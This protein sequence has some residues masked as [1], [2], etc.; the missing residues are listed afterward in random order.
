MDN[1]SPEPRHPIAVVA[2]RTGLSQ[3]VLRV[4]ERR[5][6]AVVP[7]RG[8]GGQRLYSDAD[9]ERLRLMHSTSRAGRNIGQVAGMSTEALAV[10]AAEDAAARPLVPERTDGSQAT[11][12]LLTVLA[13][14]K[15]LDAGSLSDELR[16]AATS[17]G[18]RTFIE[19]IAGPLMRRV[20]DEWHAGS[21]TVAQEHLATAA[22]HDLLLDMMRSFV[23]R[24]GAPR[25]L[26]ATPA[27]ERHVIGAAMVGA[28]AAADGWNVV[29]L[30]A[31]LP[32][33]DIAD[34]A[35]AS[36]ASVVAL[37]IVYAEERGRLLDEIGRIREELPHEVR[38]MVGGAG[39]RAMATSLRAIGVEV[40]SQIDRAY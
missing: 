35:R 11:E 10:L 7:L 24:P 33:A 36:R 29:Y 5:Y 14:A 39:A 22:L 40:V 2:E 3:D 20:G 37:S 23:N 26:V 18:V 31:D 27:G 19:T 1:L 4:W 34:A 21:L 25:M 16:R 28:S 17:L 9:I 12:I 32:A 6:S 8:P 15:A 30:G 38:L 13:H